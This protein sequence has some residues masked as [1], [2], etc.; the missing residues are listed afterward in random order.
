MYNVQNAR[1]IDIRQNN[2]RSGNLYHTTSIWL[3]ERY[4][5]RLQQLLVYFH[6]LVTS[7]IEID[8][9]YIDFRKA[10]DSVPHN[11]LLVKLWNMG[12][13]GTLWR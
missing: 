1:K 9:I 11:E 10:F 3:P 2:Q 13:T 4:I 8:A 5:N 7:K 12:I 6:Q